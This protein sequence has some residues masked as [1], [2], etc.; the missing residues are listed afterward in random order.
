MEYDDG[1]VEI[2]SWSI[3]GKKSGLWI[4]LDE[5]NGKRE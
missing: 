5:K 2:Q 4:E 1:I 3:D